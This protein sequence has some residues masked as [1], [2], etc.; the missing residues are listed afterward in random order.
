MA[1]YTFDPR[2]AIDQN[3]QP[4][5]SGFGQIYAPDDTAFAT[6]LSI[7]DLAGIPMSQVDVTDQYLTEAFRAELPV[8]VWK[9]GPHWVVLPSPNGLIDESRS[10][11][12]AAEAAQLAATQAAAAAE[13]SAQ[14]ATEA[15]EAA[16]GPSGGTGLPSGDFT[17]PFW[18]GV[19]TQPLRRYPTGHPLAGEVIPTWVHVTWRQAI[20]P[21]NGIAGDSWENS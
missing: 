6:P 1:W 4:L 3:G 20:A 9:S 21:T 7:T 8:V 18:N 2:V 11:K 15:A 16:G 17:M 10:L 19:G 12:T 13:L 5:R 14:R